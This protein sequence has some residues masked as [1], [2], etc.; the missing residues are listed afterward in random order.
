MLSILQ[1]PISQT[2]TVS[3]MSSIRLKAKEVST[4]RDTTLKITGNTTGTT[5]T[6]QV[7]IQPGTIPVSTLIPPPVSPPAGPTSAF[8]V[9]VAVPSGG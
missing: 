1:V 5:Y 3:G 9:S 8:L 2:K 7:M 6:L 4:A